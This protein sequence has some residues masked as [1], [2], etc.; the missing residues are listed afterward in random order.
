MICP[1]VKSGLWRL[2]WG[3]PGAKLPF[4]QAGQLCTS[5]SYERRLHTPLVCCGLAL[6]SQAPPSAQGLSPLEGLLPTQERLHVS[7]SATPTAPPSS[8]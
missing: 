1:V 8:L 7:W 5:P 3:P 6:T 2:A 4:P